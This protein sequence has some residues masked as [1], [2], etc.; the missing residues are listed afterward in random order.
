[1]DAGAHAEHHQHHH[2][3]M[4]TE[5]GALTGVAVAAGYRP[6]AVCMPE[7]YREWKA[8]PAA[9]SARQRSRLPKPVRSRP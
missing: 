6:C 8:D 4:P 1:M 2:H 3:E 5:G 9:F 7:R